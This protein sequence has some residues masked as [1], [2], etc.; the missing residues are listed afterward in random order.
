[1]ERANLHL[2]CQSIKN[3]KQGFKLHLYYNNLSQKVKSFFEKKE[4]SR[5]K[6]RNMRIIT[7][8]KRGN[9]LGG[10]VSELSW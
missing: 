3:Q 5:G 10:L 6:F 4:T 1:M 2:F 8:V 9:R 7:K